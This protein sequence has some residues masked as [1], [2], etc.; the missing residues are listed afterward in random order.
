MHSHGVKIRQG[1]EPN[2]VIQ[3]SYISA[4]RG[5]LSRKNSD[6]LILFYP[7]DRHLSVN[8]CLTPLPWVHGC[9][10]TTVEGIGSTKTRMHAVQ[11]R[12]AKSHGSQCGFCTPG[13]VMS[14]YTLLRNNPMPT[15]EQIEEYF[16]GK[17]T[18]TMRCF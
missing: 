4:E 14:M 6:V 16:Q 5:N 18:V 17:H 3:N 12:L 11:E 2:Q 10:V 9:A 8:A 7:H 15:M 1:I 13:F